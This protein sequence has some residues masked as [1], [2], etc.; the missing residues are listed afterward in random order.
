ME[1]F[2][3]DRSSKWLIKH[4]GNLILYLGKIRDIEEWRAGQAEVVQPR[5]LPDGLLEVSFADRDIPDLFLVEISTYPD[6]GIEE[7]VLRDAMLVFLDRRVVPFFRFGDAAQS[8]KRVGGFDP[9]R[10]EIRPCGAE[11]L[12]AAQSLRPIR[13]PPC[14]D[15]VLI[16]DPPVVREQGDRLCEDPFGVVKQA[17][18]AECFA[19]FKPTARLMRKVGSQRVPQLGGTLPLFGVA[20]RLRGRYARC[21]RRVDPCLGHF[22]HA[23]LFLTFRSQSAYRYPMSPPQHPPYTRARLRHRHPGDDRSPQFNSCREPHELLNYHI[24]CLTL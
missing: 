11:R 7:E 13:P 24:I 2:R 20:G 8:R 22:N 14:H 5:Q 19:R 10:P 15:Q 12:G 4:H 1:R 9:G 17:G 3:Y 18:F 16:A 21:P 6:R 23:V